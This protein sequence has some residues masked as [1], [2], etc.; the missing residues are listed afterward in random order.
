MRNIKGNNLNC[1][2]FPLGG[3]GTGNIS[4]AGDGSLRQWQVVNNVNHLGHVPSSFFFVQAQSQGSS[5]WKT[6]ILEKKII[7]PDDFKPA[8]TV[9]DH[10]IPDEIKQRHD[11]YECMQDLEFNGEYPFARMKYFD[12]DIPVYIELE[13][14]NPM[15]PLDVKNSALPVIFFRFNVKNP[16][17]DKNVRIRLGA[18]LLNF[19]GW[20]G[21][22]EIDLNHYSKFFANINSQFSMEKA[23]GILFHTE[24]E[25]IKDE[26]KGEIILV[27]LNEDCQVIPSIKSFGDLIEQISGSAEDNN[28]ISYKTKPSPQ[29]KT[30]C[31][32][33]INEISVAP[34]E[35][36]SVM[37]LLCWFFPNRYQNW[38][39]NLYKKVKVD[40]KSKFWLG[41]RYNMWFKN[42]E[43]IVQHAIENLDCLERKTRE[44]HDLLFNASV[45]DI[46]IDSISATMSIVRSPSCFLT[47]RGEFMGFEGCNGAST[48]H[49]QPAFGGCCPMNCN[50]VWNYAVT[51]ARLYP[52]LEISMLNNE[53][54]RI[55]KN[56]FLSHR[57]I[58]PTYLPQ[59]KKGRIGGPE[60]PA[61]DGLFGCILKTYRMLL[62]TNDFNWF[63]KA[64]PRIRKLMNYIFEECDPEG[65]GVLEGEQANTYDISFYGKNLFIGA[66]YLAALKAFERMADLLS[67]ILIKEECIKR[68]S[69]GSKNYDSSLWNGE[70]WIQIYNEKKRKYDQYGTGCL[71]DQLFGQF[72]MDMLNLGVVLPEDKINT[73][74]NSI[75]KYNYR[76]NFHGIVQ[77]PRIFAS[78]HD[79]GLLMC[80]WPKGGEPRKTFPYAYEVWTGVE[81]EVA[82]LLIERGKTD[83]ALKILEAVRGRYDGQQRNP[84]NEVECG[85]HYVR[86]ISSWRVYEA[87]IGYHWNAI[88][89][90][91]TIL[92]IFKSNP[93]QAF[94]ITDSSWGLFEMN[95]DESE[96]MIRFR[97]SYGILEMSKLKTLNLEGNSSPRI[98]EA[99]INEIN[100][101]D[102]LEITGVLNT[103]EFNFLEGINVDVNQELLLKVK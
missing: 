85:D 49:H 65:Q 1:V 71:T 20:D 39:K 50:H 30:W 80:T 37:F 16:D 66:L 77:K 98:V 103:I 54:M 35:E 21:I 29:G 46:I 68:F 58:V 38:D 82:A 61:M 73:T 92:P 9:N 44:F 67:D 2:A 4:L 70:Y 15:I 17:K 13:A 57:L 43:A 84:W 27:S 100:I 7:I 23:S 34:L 12:V 79:K 72:W 62:T 36:K 95:H 76:E 52:T 53:Y 3:I 55:S 78:E 24:N 93:F 31:G 102:Q 64:Y 56:G 40:Q 81:Y 97:P 59:I 47:K 22:T 60:H 96:Q 28:N 99:L 90:S 6:R 45:P 86:A 11:K 42:A 91:M 83:E 69:N 33:I 87:A 8:V 32:S 74:L 48:S 88:E 75:V 63:K 94:Y 41:N 19:I 26:F 10:V 14:W 18:N 51:H 5:N 101:K 89:T 25:L